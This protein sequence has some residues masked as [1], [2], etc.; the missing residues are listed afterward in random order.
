MRTEW[1][2]EQISAVENVEQLLAIRRLE[3]TIKDWQQADSKRRES[4]IPDAKE[5][6]PVA[7]HLRDRCSNADYTT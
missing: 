2:P 3:K 5:R 4:Q 7:S 1:T 6:D